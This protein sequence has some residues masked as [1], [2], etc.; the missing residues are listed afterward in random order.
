MAQVDFSSAQ[1]QDCR[2]RVGLLGVAVASGNRGVQAL[3]ASLLALLSEAA[4]DTEVVLL[5]NHD[6]A[7]KAVFPPCRQPVPVL[8][9]RLSPRAHPRDHLAVIV[10]AALAYRCLPFRVVRRRLRRAVPWIDVL[11]GARL[12]GDIRGGDSFADLYGMQRFLIGFLMAWSAVLVRG[13]IVQFPQTY[14]PYRRWISR[15]LAAYLLRRSSLILARDRESLEIAEKLVRGKRPVLLCPDVAF[16][17][18]PKEPPA[19]EFDGEAVPWSVVAGLSEPA[20]EESPI[21]LNVNGLMYNGGYTRRNMFGLRLDY[22]KFLP[23]LVEKLLEL[24][25]GEI[26]LIPHTYGPPE[27][28]ESDPEACRRVQEAL[29]AALRRRVRRVTGEYDCCELK[30][31]I[32]RCRFFIGSRMHSCIAALSQGIPTAG[33]AYSD[34]FRGVFD[35]VGVAD[36]VVDARQVDE[37]EALE[38]IPRLLEEGD[39]RRSELEAAAARA[40]ELLLSVFRHLVVAQVR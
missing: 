14:G 37:P 6:R 2:P 33:I 4:P 21:G 38:L 28:V 5:A 30:A 17:L 26:W 15:R 10:S 23:R 32:G 19:V 40:R 34:K 20:G 13:E 25:P 3:G 16:A 1:A 18:P 24:H 12:I 39:A 9:A 36:W 11:A 31:I 27:S 8:P 22:P 35:T 7:E 29:P